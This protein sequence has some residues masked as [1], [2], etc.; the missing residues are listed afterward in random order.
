MRR[1]IACS[2]AALAAALLL[3][4]CAPDGAAGTPP[5]D[6]RVRYDWRE[7]SLPPPYHYEYTITLAADG[8]GA[9]TMI[10]DYPGPG[11]P[12]W[13]EPFTLPPEDLAALYGLM[14][15]QGL[16]SEAWRELDMPPVGGSSASIEVTAGGRT[17]RIPSFPV[18]EQQERAAAIF[19]AIEAAVPRAIRDDLEA[20]RAAYE[21][22]NARP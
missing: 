4:A 22:A 3:A 19:A 12:V 17:V 8:A 11:V 21:L 5:A 1:A 14:L 6:L 9:M 15:D 13:E 7:G 16:L 2:A 20:R 10:P 18:A